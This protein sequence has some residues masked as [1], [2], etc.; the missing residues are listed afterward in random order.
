MEII[1]RPGE[2]ELEFDL[3]KQMRRLSNIPFQGKGQ[4]SLTLA[5]YPD[6]RIV[7]MELSADAE[8][9]RH[10][11]AGRLCVHTL[12]GHLQVH[13]DRQTFDVPAHSLVVLDR[14][15]AHDLYALETSRVMLTI[16]LAPHHA[17]HS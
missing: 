10:S 16:S 9:S 15:V 13:T 6:L 7:L 5:Q 3:W 11:V 1:A 12:D 14:H 17:R 4:R 2:P 8:I